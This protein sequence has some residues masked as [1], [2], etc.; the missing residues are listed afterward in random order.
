MNIPKAIQWRYST[1][2]FLQ[3][4]I[5]EEDV[6]V[7]K[8]LLRFSAS[9]VNSQP[10]HFF[11]V[12]SPEGKK[13]L[14]KATTGPYDFNTQKLLDASHVVVMCGHTKMDAGYLE[15]LLES[16]EKDGR[17]DDKNLKSYVH[18]LRSSFINQLRDTNQLDAWTDKQ[19]YLNAGML[20][21]GLGAMAIDAVPLEGFNKQLLDEELKLKEKNLR[22]VLMVALGYRAPDDSN[23]TTPKSR[24]TD[25]ITEM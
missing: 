6:K 20:L 16:E 21:M 10:W 12:S 23:A 19:V 15:K 24:L 13:R 25:V 14:T 1:K 9:S 5:S 2:K 22:S 3:K 4:K 18:E 8:D 7:V 11:L 17:Y